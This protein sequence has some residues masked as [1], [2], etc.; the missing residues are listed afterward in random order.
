MRKHSKKL[1]KITLARPIRPNRPNQHRDIA[2]LKIIEFTK[3]TE[4]ADG[5]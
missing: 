2:Q 1:D 4:A 3:G 5:D